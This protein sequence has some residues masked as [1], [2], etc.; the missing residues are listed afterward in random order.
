MRPNRVKRALMN[1]EVSL[2]IAAAARAIGEIRS[3]AAAKP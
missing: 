2:L 3:F 1:G